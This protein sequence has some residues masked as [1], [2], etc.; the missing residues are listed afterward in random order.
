[1]TRDVNVAVLQRS[2]GVW[3]VMMNAYKDNMTQIKKDHKV[4]WFFR[5]SYWKNERYYA[6]SFVALIQRRIELQTAIKQKE[7]AAK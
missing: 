1:M 7:S 6:K 4:T 2:I 3:E 5:Y